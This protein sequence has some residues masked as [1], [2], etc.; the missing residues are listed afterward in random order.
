MG[1]WGGL[2]WG[3]AHKCC[4]ELGW[5][6]SVGKEQLGQGRGQKMRITLNLEAFAWF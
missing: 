6:G 4:S 5:E 2:A 3:P 1:G